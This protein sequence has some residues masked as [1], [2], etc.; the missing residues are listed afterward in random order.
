[1]QANTCYS[2]TYKILT[3]S[4]AAFLSYFV[5]TTKF[6]HV[7]QEDTQNTDEKSKNRRP[8]ERQLN[9]THY[10][11]HT[12]R[13]T[14]TGQFLSSSKTKNK[15]FVSVYR[16]VNLQCETVSTV[17]AESRSYQLIKERKNVV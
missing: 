8:D 2:F 11:K 13:S 5:G 12:T 16:S 14:L 4:K 10:H 6:S 17:T 3:L 1:M 7:L 15:T 9:N